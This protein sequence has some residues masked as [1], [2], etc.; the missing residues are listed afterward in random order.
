MYYSRKLSVYNLCLHV[1]DTRKSYMCV[2]HEG[3]PSCGA[4]EIIS[5]FVKVVTSRITTKEKIEMWCDNCAGQN[6][7]KMLVF[8]MLYLVS[9]GWFESIECRFLVSGHSSN[10]YCSAV[11]PLDNLFL[12]L[13]MSFKSIIL[14]TFINCY[15]LQ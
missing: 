7:K 12:N 1:G 11:V 15:K 10:Y 13:F 6:K 4:N 5:S 8:A 14:I 3:I 9:S 2:W